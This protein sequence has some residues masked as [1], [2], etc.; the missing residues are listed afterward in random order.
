LL[1]PPFAD[2]PAAR[3]L[4]GVEQVVAEEVMAQ[5]HAA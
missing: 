3:T 1:R 5:V 2:A 4:D